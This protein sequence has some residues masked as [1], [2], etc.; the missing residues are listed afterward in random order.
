MSEALLTQKSLAACAQKF[1][2]FAGRFL[3]LIPAETRMRVP[4]GVNRGRVWM[5]GAANAPEWLGIYEYSKQR[6]LGRLV[7]PGENVCDIG[8]NAGFY[9]L[10]LSRIVGQGGNVFAFEPLPQNLRKLRRHLDLNKIDNV[11]VS[12][13]ALSDRIGSV[14]FE[15][16]DSDFTGRISSNARG[17]LEVPMTTLDQFL[18]EQALADPAFLKIDVEGAEAKVLLG[19]RELIARS[20]PTMLIAIHG[21]EAAHACFSILTGAGYDVASLRGRKID[22]GDD[23]PGEIIARY[24]A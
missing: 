3:Q 21:A 13:S 12:P 6:L 23:M 18:V 20:H 5:R 1:L 2:W 19:A 10:A 4:F 9:S 22:N 11:I 7:R 14:A 24:R 17:S 16:G 15:I 8:A